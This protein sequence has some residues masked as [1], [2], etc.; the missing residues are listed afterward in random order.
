MTDRSVLCVRV[1][2]MDL[3]QRIPAALQHGL[4]RSGKVR[5]VSLLFAPCLCVCVSMCMCMRVSPF[6]QRLFE[7]FS[8][9][10]SPHMNILVL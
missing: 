8:Y 10:G 4:T 2:V 5:S 6:G 9:P 1:C 7:S 3:E